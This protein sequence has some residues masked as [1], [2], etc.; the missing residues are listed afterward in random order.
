MDPREAYYYA[1]KYGPSKETREIVCKES[2]FAYW[3]AVI[4]DKGP[5]EDTREATYENSYYAYL[6]ARFVDKCFHEDTWRVV[7][8]TM[9][10][11]Y[12]KEFINS[13]MKEEVI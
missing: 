10:G 3:Y 9:W 11:E 13:L 4:V 5:R 12:Y 7:E 8:N 2:Q 1:E 6:Y